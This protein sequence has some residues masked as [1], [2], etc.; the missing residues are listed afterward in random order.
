M[1]KTVGNIARYDEIHCELAIL[2]IGFTVE[3]HAVA[4]L[5]IDNTRRST[6]SG[7]FS[8]LVVHDHAH[9]AIEIRGHIIIEVF[10]NTFNFNWL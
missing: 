9:H 10:Y 5:E 1:S 8:F 2:N 6:I 3:N 4:K 7:K